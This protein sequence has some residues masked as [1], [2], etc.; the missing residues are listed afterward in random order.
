MHPPKADS[1][2][3]ADPA[4]F[5]ASTP[6]STPGAGGDL[7]SD[8]AALPFAGIRVLDASQGLAGPYCGML[9]GQ[10][11][12]DVI[13]LEPP[14]GDWSRGIGAR[15]GSHSAI[16]LMANR[17]KR[18]LAV[19]LKKA[20]GLA[21]VRRIAAQC[22]VVIESFRPGVAGKLGIGY[23][24]LR[25]ANENLIYLSV[26]GFGQ[27]GSNAALPATDTVMQG[28]SG[29]MSLNAHADGR[30]RRLG[31]LAVD[32]L[33]ALYAFQAVSAALYGRR[34]G[35]PGRHLDVNLMQATAAFLAPK[36]IEAVLEGDRPTALNVPAGV[37]RT[38]DG[39]IAI[40]LSK[41]AQY[42]SL[43]RATDRPDLQDPATFGGFVQRAAHADLLER[44]FAAV[45]VRKTTADWLAHLAQHGVVASRVNTVQDWLQDPFVAESGAAP[46]VSEPSAG[47]LRFPRI[48]GCAEPHVGERRYA[49]PGIG[50]ENDEVLRSFGFTD[51]EA[52]ALSAAG[53]IGRS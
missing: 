21:A 2:A 40:T 14:E 49:W 16:D 42:A 26:S 53:A 38:A 1:F 30:P 4:A 50:T 33:T 31:F 22:D 34:R 9:L 52:Q 48:P 5:P 8:G 32:T 45:L 20:E 7:P 19:D 25:R 46:Q 43:C 18:S 17:G 13:K 29:M 23:E 39:W 11:G 44:E 6:A 12:A 47:T 51:A 3:S 41:E 15:Y 27:R 36:L 10:H 28:F 35:L 24:A 37:Y